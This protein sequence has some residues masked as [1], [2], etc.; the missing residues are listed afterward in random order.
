MDPWNIDSRAMELLENYCDF[1]LEAYPS[2]LPML[3][4]SDELELIAGDGCGGCFYRW[5]AQKRGDQVPVVYLS[6]YG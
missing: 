5:H 4:E 2:G 6:E 1:V 3:P